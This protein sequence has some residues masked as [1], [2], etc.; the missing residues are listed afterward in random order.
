MVYS[1]E[2]LQ[3]NEKTS[4]EDGYDSLNEKMPSLATPE[5]SV[6]NNHL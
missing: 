6:E 1:T 3:G 2:T 5:T 4:L